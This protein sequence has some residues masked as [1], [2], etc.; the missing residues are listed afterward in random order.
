[1]SN[2]RSLSSYRTVENYHET[3]QMLR[4]FFMLKGFLEVETQSKQSIL[5]AC[6]DPQSIT[7][8][9]IHNQR[10][11]LPQTGQMLLECELLKNPSIPGLFSVTTSYRDE[12][13]INPTR[14]LRVFPLFEFESHGTFADL[15]KLLKELLSFLGFGK[16]ETFCSGVYED[17][18]ATCNTRIIEAIHEEDLCK[19]HS[20]VF[21]LKKF[22]L[23][24]DPFWN[25]KQANRLALKI[26]TL[27]Y[28]METIGSAERSI[29]PIEMQQSFAKLSNG[30][31]AQLLYNKF[32]KERVNKELEQFL[33]LTFF[34]R[35]GGGIGID[36]LIR[37]ITLSHDLISINNCPTN[38]EKV[39]AAIL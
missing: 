6:E 37:A 27:L 4:S 13:Q 10:W 29:D 25:I 15:E 24:T 31:Y 8:Y 14:H 17:I 34:N 28:G 19:K 3:V 7:D 18:A 35:F 23:Y 9:Y 11:P 2:L 38:T 21:L 1:M 5:A 22:P 33:G 30:G 12:Q 16:A 39:D 36:R 26:D 32:G 20:P